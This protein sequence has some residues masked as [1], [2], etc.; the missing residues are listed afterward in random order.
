MEAPTGND[1]DWI[2][3]V[4]VT[5]HRRFEKSYGLKR[6]RT[7]LG[8][9]LLTSEGEEWRER[10][11]VMQ[12]AFHR[13]SIM[14]MTQ[15]MTDAGCKMLEEWETKFSEGEVVEVYTEMMHVTLDIIGRTLFSM[16]LSSKT[17][18]TAHAF[19]VAFC[20]NI[21][22]CKPILRKLQQNVSLAVSLQGRNPSP[23]STYRKFIMIRFLLIMCCVILVINY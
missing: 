8:D 23:E 13:P 15:D 3:Q 20:N 1:P 2:K 9:G 12:P 21:Q 22:K 17:D 10:R 14:S 6:L 19:H 16:D 7:V 4:L 18:K 11:R 5:D